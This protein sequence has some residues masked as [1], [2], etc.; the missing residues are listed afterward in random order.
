M[1]Q[2]IRATPFTVSLS[3]TDLD[4]FNTGVAWGQVRYIM[5]RGTDAN[6]IFNNI[7]EL[8]VLDT[9][10]NNL[11]ENGSL[12]ESNFSYFYGGGH[13]ST[14]YG[15]RLFDNSQSSAY[16]NA[17]FSVDN[18][19]KWILIDLNQIVEVGSLII[20]ARSNSDS[21][22]ARINHMT[23]YASDRN[24]TG[25]EYT[26]T[27][28]GNADEDLLLGTTKK[29][30]KADATLKWKDLTEFTTTNTTITYESA[31]QTIRL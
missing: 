24:D 20:Q 21:H 17:S 26:G 13:F 1:L 9:D 5:F 2:E 31:N 27:P 14:Q 23:V 22:I 16:A 28:S 7:G 6:G 18:G 10:G 19:E 8:D 11:I 4:E 3:I 15:P 25:F 12:N 30:M 29:Q